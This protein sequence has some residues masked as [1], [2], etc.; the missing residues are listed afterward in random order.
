MDEDRK[1]KPKMACRSDRECPLRAK[2]VDALLNAKE[3]IIVTAPQEREPVFRRY[4]RG[5]IKKDFR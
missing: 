3:K 4:K 5:R 2:V 1:Y